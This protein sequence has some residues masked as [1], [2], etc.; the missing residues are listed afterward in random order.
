[1]DQFTREVDEEYRR[2]QVMRLW[3]R[4][5]T[6]VVGAIALVVV[7]VA[8]YTLWQGQQRGAAEEASLRLYEA[9]RLMAEERSLE[10]REILAELTDRAPAGA[11]TLARL[12]LAAATADA[13]RAA[14]AEAFDA[15]ARDSASPR[16]LRDLA[17]LRAAMLRLDTAPDQALP[18]LQ[19]LAAPEGTFRH[20]AREQLGLAALGR[21]D[22]EAAGRWFD[23]I[24][25]DPATPQALRGRLELYAAIVAA[26]PVAPGQ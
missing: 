5:G 3:K 23:E 25:A 9:S 1:M 17:Q 6:L 19:G 13:D 21:G 20:T 16:A 15:I 8:G 4:Y 14:G 22:Y 7:G 11:A 24:A 2:D 12:R 18:V 10:G 26:G